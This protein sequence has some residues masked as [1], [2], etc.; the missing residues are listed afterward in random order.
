MSP[1]KKL[2]RFIRLLPDRI[3]GKIFVI[4]CKLRGLDFAADYDRDFEK[5]AGHGYEATTERCFRA[6]LRH[7]PLPIP[8]IRFLDVGCGKGSVLMYARK[9]G[10][11]HLG[12]VELSQKF[13]SIC[14]KNF[15]ILRYGNIELI[16][17]DAT[18]LG[19]V[20]D[21]YNVI[22][23]FNPFPAPVVEAFLSRVIESLERRPREAYVVYDNP[24]EADVFERAGFAVEN[25]IVVPIYYRDRKILIYRSPRKI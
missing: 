16:R 6:A 14:E 1:L 8:D 15:R 25:S 13:L 23:M 2:L 21:G 20:L 11:V 19:D 5:S 12:G 22:Y 24:L 7:I 10:I 18:T 4:S 9:A 17:Q 3:K